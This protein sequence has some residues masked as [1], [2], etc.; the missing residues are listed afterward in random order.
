MEKLVCTPPYMETERVPPAP[1]HS[2]APKE[3]KEYNLEEKDE[4]V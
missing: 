2:V 3:G 4:K 1:T